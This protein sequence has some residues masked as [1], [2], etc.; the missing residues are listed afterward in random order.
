MKANMHL[1]I[2]IY[3][4]NSNTYI[5]K[6]IFTMPLKTVTWKDSYLLNHANEGTVT[7]LHSAVAYI[8]IFIYIYIMHHGSLTF[9]LK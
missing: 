6:Y 8:I 4:V 5:I 7:N 2:Y 9:F 1:F 3:P